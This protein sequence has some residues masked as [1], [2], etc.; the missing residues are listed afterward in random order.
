VTTPVPPVTRQLVVQ[1]GQAQ[2]FRVF[3]E[4]MDRW[5][6]R[7]HHIGQSPMK[8]V[9]VEP[10]DGGR[11]YATCE[12][13]SEC[14]TG[15]V[16]VWDPPRRLV[17]SWQI[18]ADWIFDPS[19]MT[20]IEVVFTAVGP[21]TTRVDFEHRNLERYG[22]AAAALRGQLDDPKGWP[23]NLARYAAVAGMKAV[24][25]YETAPE[26]LTKAPLHYPAHKVRVD[27]F[28]ARGDLLAVGL[29]SDPRE[30]SM[31]VF[32][33]REAA[34]EFVRDDPFVVNGVVARATIKDWNETLLR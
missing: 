16:L 10:R 21:R 33:T 34:E 26:G 12:D 3:T 18:T 2:A 28:A 9:L 30:G 20:E 19:F 6:P 32:A 22:E 8:K 24:I 27:A 31:G 17:L 5:W 13:G 1:V 29:F 11:W 4:G 25:F 14:D 15:R 7:E 23:G